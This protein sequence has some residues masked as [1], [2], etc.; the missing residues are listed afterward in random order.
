MSTFAE[1]KEVRTCRTVPLRLLR[2]ALRPQF[3]AALPSGVIATPEELAAA[4][5]KTY[6]PPIVPSSSPAR[7]GADSADGDG[8]ANNDDV[9]DDRLAR[10]AA[11]SGSGGARSSRSAKSTARSGVPQLSA[12]P[13]ADVQL[14][15]PAK[16]VA[17]G[18]QLLRE[19]GRG[20]RGLTPRT[21]KGAKYGIGEAGIE[22][23]KGAAAGARATDCL[24]EG[25]EFLLSIPLL[26]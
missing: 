7:H 12:K 5:L 4:G 25:G 21:A 16:V 8:A 20:G 11:P 24:G 9:V 10:A 22:P 2:S 18:I 14:P 1:R 26:R 19:S 23:M 15:K 13:A 17:W 6:A 3:L